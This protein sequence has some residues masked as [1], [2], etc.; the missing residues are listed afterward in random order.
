MKINNLIKQIIKEEVGKSLTEA[1]D[2]YT[3][4]VINWFTSKGLEVDRD[5]KNF[6]VYKDGKEIFKRSTKSFF[7]SAHLDS[8]VNQVSKILNIDNDFK[9]NVATRPQK[10]YY[11]LP[12]TIIKNDLFAT[13][14][15]LAKFYESQLN[16][17]DVDINLFDSIIKSLQDIRKSVETY[18]KK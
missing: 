9:K 1:E 18:D 12:T 13:Q 11:R 2:S 8:F 17:N 7:R 6:R 4:K 3:T 10:Y 14:K 5:S 15:E 16:G